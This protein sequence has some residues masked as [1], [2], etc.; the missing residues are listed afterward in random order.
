MILT[1]WLHYAVDLESDVIRKWIT[2][3]SSA[4]VPAASVGIPSV[5]SGILSIIDE[6]MDTYLDM[7]SWTKVLDIL[8]TLIIN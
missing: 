5:Y 1:D 7:L 6:P 4:A 2:S 3:S 8:K